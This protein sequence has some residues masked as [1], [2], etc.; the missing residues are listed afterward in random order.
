MY[1]NCF[2]KKRPS[3]YDNVLFSY[4]SLL[5]YTSNHI[6]TVYNKFIISVVKFD[7]FPLNDLKA[8]SF[9]DSLFISSNSS[10]L[11]SADGVK[12]F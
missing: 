6:T 11:K 3:N 9:T 4:I 1:I 12:T 10:L 2:A 7:F 8:V 5:D